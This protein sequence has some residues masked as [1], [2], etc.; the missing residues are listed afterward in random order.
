MRIAWRVVATMT[1][2]TVGVTTYQA[3]YGDD[4][5]VV[6]VGLAVSIAGIFVV[7]LTYRGAEK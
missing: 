5:G 2:I 6:L 4:I 7:A 1:A 3:W